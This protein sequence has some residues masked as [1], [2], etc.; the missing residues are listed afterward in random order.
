VK[1]WLRRA[2]REALG[3]ERQDRSIFK[4]EHE[5]AQLREQAASFSELL[6][7]NSDVIENLAS[8]LEEIRKSR[9]TGSIERNEPEE[10]LNPVASGFMPFSKRKR[11]FEAEHRKD[12]LNPTAKQ[13]VDNAKAIRPKKEK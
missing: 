10:E 2:L 7:N 4:L 1:E 13:I 8:D 11:A 5:L 6:Q 3:I 12:R 9:P